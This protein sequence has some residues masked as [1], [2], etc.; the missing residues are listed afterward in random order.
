MNSQSATDGTRDGSGA[1]VTYTGYKAFFANLFKWAR[2][3]DA[4]V[5]LF[6]NDYGIEEYGE[7]KTTQMLNLVQ[8]LKNTHNAPIDGVGLQSHFSLANINA[9]PNFIGKVVEQ[10]NKPIELK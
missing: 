10:L 8:E 7:S 5:P 9:D 3:A 4:N 1:F 2:A 6:Y